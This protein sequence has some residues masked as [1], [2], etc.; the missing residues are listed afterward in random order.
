MQGIQGKKEGG[1]G[2]RHG[3]AKRRRKNNFVTP[4]QT[5]GKIKR[6]G[7]AA[8]IWA[9]RSTATGRE[10]KSRRVIGMLERRRSM[11]RW[12]NDLVWQSEMLG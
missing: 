3:G 10:R 7:E 9:C 4:R 2:G 1:R 5:R 6:G 8:G 12:A 11:P